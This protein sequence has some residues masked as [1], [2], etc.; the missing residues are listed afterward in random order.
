LFSIFAKIRVERSGGTTDFRA[1]SPP[2]WRSR[3]NVVFVDVMKDN[4]RA[5]ALLPEK[6]FQFSR[7]LTRMYRG[8]NAHRGRPDLLYAILGPGFG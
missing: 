1:L 5:L 3:C 6:G 4:P 2:L 8:E 7:S